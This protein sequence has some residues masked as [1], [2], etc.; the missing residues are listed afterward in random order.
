MHVR[1][2]H[3][4]GRVT[5]SGEP[6]WIAP[7]MHR[8]LLAALPQWSKAPATYCVIVD[9]AAGDFCRGLDEAVLAGLGA[10]DPGAAHRALADAYALAW[11][12]DC[13]T[14]PTIPLIDGAVAGGGA[15][16]CLYGT[17]AVAGERY[18]LSVPGPAH[19]WF[20]DHGLASVLA[21]MPGGVGRYLALTGHGIG[22][23]DAY[24]L[25]LLTHC[26]AA[27]HFA[28]ITAAL[29]DADPVDPIL[30]GLHEDPGEGLLLA[31]GDAIARS[32][33]PESI[34]DI[35]AQLEQTAGPSA[36][37]CAAAAR[38]MRAASPLGLK[39]T[40]RLLQDARDL[41]LR[42][43]LVRDYRVATRLV[44]SAEFAAGAGGSARASWPSGALAQVSEG[45]VATYFAPLGS[46]DLALPTRSALQAPA[47]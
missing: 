44:R 9:A 22:R 29:C 35:L 43:Q 21:R 16:L 28:S 38:S 12:I 46:D 8:R 23:A 37:F 14:K 33:A 18:T 30:D 42:Q 13:F 4:G 39:I 11:Q 34:E 26:I 2:E 32:F 25:R 3:A 31:H 10:R 1:D 47:V 7:A 15:A 24:R 5:F 45:E 17:H 20:P 19:G 36:A 6:R 40:L 27:Q 41:D